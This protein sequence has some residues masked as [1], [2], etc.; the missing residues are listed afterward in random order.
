[1]DDTPFLLCTTTG[2]VSVFSFIP[3]YQGG[4]FSS[5]F[6]AIY[7]FALE[8]ASARVQL[9]LISTHDT[10]FLERGGLPFFFVYT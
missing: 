9:V 2:V 5:L 8:R 3:L 1:M 4:L 10:D 7:M 6:P